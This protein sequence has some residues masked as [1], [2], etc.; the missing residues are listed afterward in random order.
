MTNLPLSEFGTKFTARSGIGELMEDLGRALA[1]GGP[2]LCMLG[3]GNP[4][5]IPEVEQVFRQRMT[6]LMAEPRAYERMLGNYDPPQGNLELASAIAHLFNSEYGWDL[7]PENVA[8]TNGSQNAFFALFNMLAGQF[9]D[10]RKRRILFPITP[11]YIGYVDQ[12]LGPDC[13]TATRPDIELIGEHRYKYRVDFDRLTIDDDVAAI[14]FSRPTNPSGNV[15]TDAEVE[16]LSALAAQH[17]I[18]LIID[19]A[20]GAPFPNIL[21]TD[22][23]PFWAP[24]VILSMSLSKIGLP[25]TRTGIVIASQEV[26]KALSEVNAILSL[27]PGSV[28]SYL[29]APLIRNGELLRLSREVIQPFYHQRAQQALQ[30]LDDAMDPAVDYRVHQSE[31]AMFLWVWFR[32]LSITTQEL[33]ERLKHCGVIIVPGHYFFPGLEEDWDHRHQ[34]IRINYAHNPDAVQRGLKIIAD[35]VKLALA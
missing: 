2:D 24:H 21:F 8:I 18:P 17:G 5:P 9:P 30:W 19:N 29:A 4:A 13:F 31:G 32:N 34:C 28:G 20:Y 22:V 23:K 33:Y 3:G 25:G 7:G 6:E 35:E 1:A 14:C 11:E 12:G 10:G 15:V 27:A 26:I 16:Q